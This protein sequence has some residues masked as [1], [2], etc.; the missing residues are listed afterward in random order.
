MQP[1]PAPAGFRARFVLWVAQ[2]F[3]TGRARFAPGTFGTLPGL[4]WAI[5]LMMPGNF[6]FYSVMTLAGL[7][8]SVWL[9]G[10]AERLLGCSDPSSVVLDEIT[11][12]PLCF[13]PFCLPMDPAGGF[14][15][16]WIWT[17]RG[18]VV[19]ALAFGLFRLFDIW[20]PWPVRQSQHLPEG[21]GVT[22]DDALAAV[23]TAIAL[24][25][26]FRS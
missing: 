8:C 10:E 21:W 12:M 6:W 5:L 22:V 11:A 4:L 3:G 18:G 14:A 1:N 7:G 24:G 13:L 2:G 19:C 17:A 15:S 25:L 26:C 23:Y 9:C 20:K 16:D